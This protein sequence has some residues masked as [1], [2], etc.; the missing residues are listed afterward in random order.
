[1]LRQITSRCALPQS[2]V[3]QSGLLSGN[4]CQ[5]AGSF[6]TR[7]AV[8]SLTFRWANFDISAAP[9]VL[10]V[11]QYPVTIKASVVY[12]GVNYPIMWAQ[13]RTATLQPDEVLASLPLSISIPTNTTF[14]VR[15]LITYQT[16][17]TQWCCSTRYN[18]DGWNQFGTGLT[19]IIDLQTN[20]GV[21]Q[22]N[23]MVLPPMHIMDENTSAKSAVIMSDS[24]GSDGS[25]D[26]FQY[27]TG[28]SQKLFDAIG[29]PFT[30]NGASGN[31]LV[32]Q[33]QS[34]GSTAAEKARRDKS[35][36]DNSAMFVH[37]ALATNDFASGRTNAQIYADMLT[38]K[39]R[40]DAA[41]A[42]LIVSTCY[43]R[44]DPTNTVK[45][46]ADSVNVWTYR[47]NLNDTIRANNGVGYGYFDVAAACQDPVSIDLWRSDLGTPTND[48]VHP[49]AVIHDAIVAYLTQPAAVVTGIWRP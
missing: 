12:G 15:W 17:P 20:P 41:G 46:A 26:G 27:E 24:I 37:C 40:C 30:N 35:M 9:S 8:T 34:Y 18:T 39:A 23:F 2:Y 14:S 47:R 21:R 22:T 25:N 4:Q 36:M 42:K 43:P 1:M 48:G 6:V 44:T 38:M 29:I 33:V 10:L 13:G 49:N 31:S 32:I 3:A 19:D 16:A 45:N 11:G 28:W 7:R 5:Q